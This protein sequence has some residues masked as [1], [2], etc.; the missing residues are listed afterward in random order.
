MLASS[1]EIAMTSGKPMVRRI[2]AK[3]GAVV[4]PAVDS[5]VA[6]SESYGRLTLWTQLFYQFGKAS[7]GDV[8]L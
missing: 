4:P 6:V 5:P 3:A 2:S 7:D 1:R 8:V